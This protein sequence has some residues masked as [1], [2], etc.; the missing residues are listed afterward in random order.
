MDMNIVCRCGDRVFLCKKNDFKAV[1][2]CGITY[3]FSDIFGKK[4]KV[5]ITI[6]TSLAED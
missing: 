4:R 1:C 2:S 6:E 5:K 3:D